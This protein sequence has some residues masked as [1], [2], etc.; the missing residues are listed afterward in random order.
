MTHRPKKRFGQHF[1]HDS[2]VISQIITHIDPKPQ[3]HL[4]EIGPG[5]GVLTIQL[6]PLVKS[7]D[8]IELDRDLIAPLAATCKPLGNINIHAYDVL[9]FDFGQL[10]TEPNDLRIVGNL[11]YQISTPL[12]FHLIIY[13]D[14]I[15]DL[16]FM[17]QKEVVNRLAA[18][19]GTKSYGRLS[20]MVQYHFQVEKLFEVD[21]TAFY[22]I[23]QVH[24]AVV[25]LVPKKHPLPLT[26]YQ[27]FSDIVREAFN[28]RRKTLHNCL[29][30]IITSQQLQSLGIDPDCRPEQLTVAEFVNISNEAVNEFL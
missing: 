10:T 16:H 11:P 26:N 4:V 30:G 23:P 3:D 6:L 12:L 27:L 14:L 1:L 29:R 21:P 25:R 15:K 18:S 7:M 19:S 13:I 2:E 5:Q 22:P 24:S 20:I 28:H 8:V 9:K 17:L